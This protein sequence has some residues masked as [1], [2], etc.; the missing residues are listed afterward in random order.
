[1]RRDRSPSE[2]RGRVPHQT[3]GNPGSQLPGT[4]LG[5]G[6]ESGLYGSVT[7][8]FPLWKNTN[9]ISRSFLQEVGDEL[10]FLKRSHNLLVNGRL[11]TSPHPRHI[12]Q[13][14]KLTGVKATS[15]PKRVPGHPS[16]DEVENL[17]S[18]EMWRPLST[19]VAW[20]L[21]LLGNWFAPCAAFHPASIYGHELPNRAD[22]GH[23][24]SSC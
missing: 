16:I 19:E 15:K 17:R 2:G 1:M 3:W 6:L 7:N 12:E 24:A 18:W 11:A 22:E 9:K 4:G 21:A 10:T 23:L 13:L 14:M 5:T 20:N 8:W